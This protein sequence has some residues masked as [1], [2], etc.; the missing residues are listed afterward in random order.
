MQ[1][2]LEGAR[3]L[4]WQEVK[5]QIGDDLEDECF[6]IFESKGRKREDIKG[7]GEEDLKR[8]YWDA[9]VFGCTFLE[10][11]ARFIKTGVA[12]FGMGVSVSPVLIK[13]YTITNKASVEEETEQGMGPLAYR[14]VEHGVYAMPFTINPNLADQTDCQKRDIQIML[15]LIRHAYPC[16]PSAIRPMVEIKHAWYMEHKSPLGSCSDFALI[17]AMKPK[18]KPEFESAKP[19]KCLEEEYDVPTALPDDLRGRIKGIWDVAK[20]EWAP[21]AGRTAGA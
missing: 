10:K 13:R 11:G 6:C 2:E 16:N 3:P 4:A 7:K 12:Q 20:E 18:R 9:R 21:N 1:R 15:A 8:R 14:I 5:K 17:D 19:S